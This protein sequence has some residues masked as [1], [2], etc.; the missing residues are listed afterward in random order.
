[1][2]ENFCHAPRRWQR[3]ASKIPIGLILGDVPLKADDSAITLDISP[4]GASVR[5][6]QALVPG[7]WVK[8]VAREDDTQAIEALVVWVREDEPSHSTIAG[9]ELF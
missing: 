2:Q 4:R 8:V 1:M 7:D 5:T 6:R 3:Q 9:L